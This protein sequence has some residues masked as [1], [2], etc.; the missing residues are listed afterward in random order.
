M[1]DELEK[2]EFIRRVQKNPEIAVELLH[3][4]KRAA[5]VMRILLAIPEKDRARIIASLT[6]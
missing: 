3:A 1:F 5:T 2:L 4:C 6:A